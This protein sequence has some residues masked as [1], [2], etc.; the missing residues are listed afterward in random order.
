MN[1]EKESIASFEVDHTTLGKGIHISR[2][3]S[4]NGFKVTT[5]D[6]RICEPNAEYLDPAVSHT[7]EHLGAV[8]F[9]NHTPLDVV[10]FG[11]MGC[12]TGMYLVLTGN[13][14]ADLVSF[15]VR[16]WIAWSEK[17]DEIPGCSDKE[18]GNYRLHDLKSARDI[19]TAF[20]R[21]VPFAISC[22]KIE[23][24][25]CVGI[26]KVLYDRLNYL[27]IID[28]MG[29]RNQNVGK[30]D[31]SNKKH[32]I[33]PW[34]IWRDYDLDPWSAD[35]VKRILRTKEGDSKKLDLCKIKHIC[36]ELIRQ[37][38]YYGAE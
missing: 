36:D 24:A 33:Q 16:E 9:R 15:Y 26:P 29:V 25:E 19:L 1:T 2:E 13:A 11:P 10:Y 4:F 6:I 14:N 21:Y 12:L 5:Y 18:C 35:I 34:S 7:I 31:Y 22:P 3:D 23:D 30:S 27:G 37:I 38:D 17:V 20:R 8:F 32:L 28:E